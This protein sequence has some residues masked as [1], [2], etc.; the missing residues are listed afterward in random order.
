[1]PS[2]GPSGGAGV[3]YHRGIFQTARPDLGWRVT[4]PDASLTHSLASED[5]VVA[6]DQAEAA[7]SALLACGPVIS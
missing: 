1:M 7:T 6:A 4:S 3:A 5:Y 2:S